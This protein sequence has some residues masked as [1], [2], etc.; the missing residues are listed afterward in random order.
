[1][2]HFPQ[3]LLDHNRELDGHDREN[4]YDEQWH[5]SE[6]SSQPD[7]DQKAANDFDDACAISGKIGEG[8]TNTKETAG[9]Q[10]YGENK[11]L[12]TF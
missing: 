7:Q 10:F 6:A 8:K 9:A 3:A 5:R 2:Q 4:S 1:M 11:F 12:D